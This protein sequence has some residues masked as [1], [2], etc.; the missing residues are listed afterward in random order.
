MV[1]DC[2]TVDVYD[3]IV[4][5][6][7]NDFFSFVKIIQI[8]IFI[9]YNMRIPFLFILM[10]GYHFAFTQ[11]HLMLVGTYNTTD[12]FG[13]QVV[14]FNSQN[15][16]ADL[17][18]HYQTSNPS[19][20][21]LSPNSNFVYAVNEDGADKGGRVSSLKIDKKSGRLTPI[22]HQPSNGIHP[23]YITTDKKGKWILAGNY[24]SG[25]LSVLPVRKG[26]ISPSIQTIQHTGKGPDS[27]R[28]QSPHV[29]G[30]FINP[31]SGYVYVTDLGANRIFKYSMDKKNGHLKAT[32]MPIIRGITGNGPRHLDFHPNGKFIYVLNELSNEIAVVKQAGEDDFEIQSISSLPI[33]FK[34]TSTAADIHISSDGNFLY[35]SNRGSANSIGIY[36]IDTDNGFLSLITHTYT[37]GETPR[38][39]NFDPTGRFLLVANQNSNSIAIFKREASTGLITDTGNRIKINKPV[40]IK[41]VL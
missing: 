37:G 22:N 40:C 5:K 28:Q 36:K 26:V 23:C 2:I 41:W 29:H 17:L 39:F 8:L 13:I 24:T 25:T 38:N 21:A 3:K 32:K 18:T 12:S 34:G 4:P 31:N 1:I 33:T 19:Y 9:P 35:C 10:L 20:L 15:G 11:Q 16:S 30:V 14:R 27:S 7:K 6:C